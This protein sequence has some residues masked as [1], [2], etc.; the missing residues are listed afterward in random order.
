V[1]MFILFKILGFL[2]KQ[3]TGVLIGFAGIL[4]Y[5]LF[6]ETFKLSQGA[7]ILTFLLA[8]YEQRN[9]L[10]KKDKGQDT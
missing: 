5:G 7:F 2:Y 8:M 6:H 9:Y 3:D 1:Y 4:I 10:F